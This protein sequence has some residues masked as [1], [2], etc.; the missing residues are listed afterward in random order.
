MKQLFYRRTKETFEHLIKMKISKSKLYEAWVGV[1]EV[2]K[3]WDERGTGMFLFQIMIL[4]P[5]PIL[6]HL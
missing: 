3:K 4:I 2:Q 1:S 5:D 6:F